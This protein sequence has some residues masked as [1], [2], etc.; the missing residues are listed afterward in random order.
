M[1]IHFVTEDTWLIFIAWNNTIPG[2]L[3][4]LSF[5]G[6]YA[7]G[8]SETLVEVPKHKYIVQTTIKV[9]FAI[10]F[11]FSWK[12][13]RTTLFVPFLYLCWIK[14]CLCLWHESVSMNSLCC[15]YGDV[16][17]VAIASQITASWLFTQP[18]IQTQIKLN[19][20]APRHWPFCGEFTG[21]RWIPRTNG[22]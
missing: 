22:R 8:S 10:H 14:R 7:S 17:M 4:F 1:D 5:G 15:H 13:H 18:F 2:C 6:F 3:L 9:A 16:I 20:K 21:D 12:F 19:I 11:C